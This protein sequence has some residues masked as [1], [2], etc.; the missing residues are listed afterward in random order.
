MT[1]RAPLIIDEC[2]D[3]CGA[4]GYGYALRRARDAR[5]ASAF[6][7]HMAPRPDGGGRAVEECQPLAYCFGRCGAENSGAVAV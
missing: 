3:F 1:E 6:A 5:A 7:V 2:G 4:A